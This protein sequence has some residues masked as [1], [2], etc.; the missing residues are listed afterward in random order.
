[1]SKVTIYQE[2]C[3]RVAGF[4]EMGE[5]FMRSLVINGKSRSTHDYLFN[6]PLRKGIVKE[7]MGHALLS[8]TMIYLN[9][10]R[11]KAYN[12]CGCLDNLYLNKVDTKQ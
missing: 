5:H 11:L 12:V 3:N 6:H 10:A 7:A 4:Q 2:A 9:I 8:A 1:M